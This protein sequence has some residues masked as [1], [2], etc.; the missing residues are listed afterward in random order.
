M[1]KNIYI[2]ISYVLLTSCKIQYGSKQYY[3][4]M[5]ESYLYAFKMNYFQRLLL[6]GFNRSDEIKNILI[7]DR[8]GYGEP[9]LS[10][11]DIK[12]TDSLVKIDNEIMVQDSLNSIG[13]VGEGAQGK[14]V[15]AYALYRYQGKWLDSLAKERYKIYKHTPKE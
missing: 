2:L 9:I 12:I 1:K 8:S 4:Q 5:R 3:H 15:F 7:L 14:H 11:Q 10:N 13:R 6:E